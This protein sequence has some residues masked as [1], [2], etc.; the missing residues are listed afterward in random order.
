MSVGSEIKERE[1]DGGDMRKTTHG[2]TVVHSLSRIVVT[3]PTSHAE[4][5]PLNCFASKNTDDGEDIETSVSVESEMEKRERE[6]RRR[7]EEDNTRM[8][9]RTLTP[10]HISDLPDIP[11]REV[12]VELIRINKH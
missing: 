10:S 6:R 5:S 9:S 7:H 11:C 12:S 8:D 2:W 4:R 3:L 1:R